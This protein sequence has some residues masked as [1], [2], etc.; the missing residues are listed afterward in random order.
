METASFTGLVK[1]LFTI[2]LIYYAAKFF[3]KLFL[4]VMAQQV[5]RKAQENMENQ[6]RFYEDQQNTRQQDN[7]NNNANGQKSKDKP[8]VGEYIDYEEID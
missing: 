2:I 8:V 1:A 5:V 4:P 6:R 3:M 7:Y